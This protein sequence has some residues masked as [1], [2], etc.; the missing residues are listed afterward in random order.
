MYLRQ[1]ENQRRIMLRLC[2]FIFGRYATQSKNQRSIAD[3]QPFS[4][5]SF[6]VI[7]LKRDADLNEQSAMI[8]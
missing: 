5:N 7:N 8:F 4:V 1:H 6:E 3:Q 2:A